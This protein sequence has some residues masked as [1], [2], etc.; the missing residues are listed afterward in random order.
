MEYMKKYQCENFSVKVLFS[1]VLVVVVTANGWCVFEVVFFCCC[2]LLLA[3]FL[4][5]LRGF[6]LDHLQWNA[7]P[8]PISVSESEKE[9]WNSLFHLTTFV[10]VMVFSLHYKNASVFV[11]NFLS[12]L[13]PFYK[14]YS[15]TTT[16][17]WRERIKKIFRH[18]N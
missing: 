1:V 10:S 2:S 4:L 12:I 7:C 18:L 3:V 6:C 15:I 9:R 13:L 16:W 17:R 5:F 14:D 8:K 11:I